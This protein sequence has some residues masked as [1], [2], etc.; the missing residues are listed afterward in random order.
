MNYLK[1]LIFVCL[2]YIS[3]GYLYDDNDNVTNFGLHSFDLLFNNTL[4]N[5]WFI[6]FYHSMCGHCINFAPMFKLFMKD[7]QRELHLCVIV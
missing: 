6:E 2:L 5:N 1:F 7:A 3:D 4:N